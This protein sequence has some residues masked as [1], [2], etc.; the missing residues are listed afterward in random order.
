MAKRRISLGLSLGVSPRESFWNTVEVVKKAEGYGFESVAVTD[1]P[2]SMKDC[3]VALALCAANTSRIFLATGVTNPVTRE[4][5]TTASAISA[6]HELS[7]GRAILGLGAGYSAVYP[8][9]LQPATVKQVEE[10]IA[11]VRALCEGKEYVKGDHRVRLATARGRVP[12]YVAASQPKMLELAGRAA[13][14]VILMGG[15][16]VQF[17]AWQLEH[18]RRGAAAAGRGPDDLVVDL[19]FA[20]SVAED[21]EVALDEVRPWAVSQ[22]DTFSKYKALP[23]FLEPFRDEIAQAGQAYERLEHLSRHARHKGIIS[24]ELVRTLAVVG[25][26]KE[27]IRRLRELGDIGVDRMTLAL[28]SGGRR[29]RMRIIAETIMPH[30]GV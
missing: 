5:A 4:P 18:V 17:T 28:L 9:G 1:V 30:L 13:D 16:N 8:V 19:W 15:A 14:G 21:P 23:E 22:A 29:E 26:P 7:G 10:T 25:D 24:D 11:Y 20:L 3:Y 12:I 27:C 2:L 6:V